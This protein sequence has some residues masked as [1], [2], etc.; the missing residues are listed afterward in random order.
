MIY[1]DIAAVVVVALFIW[2]VPVRRNGIPGLRGRGKLPMGPPPSPPEQAAGRPAPLAKV[3]NLPEQRRH[4]PS[5]RAHQATPETAPETAQPEPGRSPAG[6]QPE[7][8]RRPAG[9]RPENG[10]ALKLLTGSN[11]PA[12]HLLSG[13]GRPR[14]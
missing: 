10:P 11:W 4:E 14:L 6:A 2:L 13:H 9:A 3:I 12:D 8:G 5:G 1:E 7:P